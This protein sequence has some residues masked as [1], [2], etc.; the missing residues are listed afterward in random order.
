MLC[1]ILAGNSE[2]TEYGLDLIRKHANNRVA[3]MR[4]KIDLKELLDDNW[5]YE[6]GEE[7]Y[8]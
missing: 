6:D 4:G 1:Q 5:V 8:E 3:K 2:I 7:S